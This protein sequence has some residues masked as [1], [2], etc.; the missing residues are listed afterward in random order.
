MH[1]RSLQ[2]RATA[3]RL[4][5]G[6]TL[7]LIVASCGSD[8][9]GPSGSLTGTWDLIG[10]ADMGVSAVTTGTAEFRADGTFGVS[11]TITFP[12]EPTE[13]LA[14]E[15]TYDQN[16]RTVALT[17]GGQT[18][19]WTILVSGEEVTLTEVAPPPASTIVLSG[20]S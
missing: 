2:V 15:G 9:T 5:L 19:N 13:P 8:S 4:C 11:G 14:V 3:V 16:R 20:R 6:L 17:I 18:S 10:F 7:A 12:G 1:V